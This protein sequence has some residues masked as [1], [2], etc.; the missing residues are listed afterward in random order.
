MKGEAKVEYQNA[1]FEHKA[2]QECV[3][4]TSI[5]ILFDGRTATWPTLAY[6]YI[7]TCIEESDTQQ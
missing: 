7:F 5:C 4:T 6:I 3:D 1:K 2:F